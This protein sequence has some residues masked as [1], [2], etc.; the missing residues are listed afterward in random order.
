M[1]IVESHVEGED[2]NV[3]VPRGGP[4]YVS[5]FISPLTGVS[6]FRA[7]VVEHL[8]NLRA[9]VCSHMSHAC[10]EDIS[11]DELKIF[12][13]EEFVSEAFKQVFEGGTDAENVLPIAVEVP[14]ERNLSNACLEN[15]E[16]AI[17]PLDGSS[18]GSDSNGK[19]N[20]CNSRKTKKRRRKV[21]KNNCAVEDNYIAKV[22][23]L[24]KVKQK[25]DE[26]KAAVRLHSFNGGSKI[27]SSPEKLEGTKFL[28]STSSEVKLPSVWIPLSNAKQVKSL[29]IQ[30]HI[31]VSYPEVVLSVE[32][33]HNRRTFAKIQEF[34]VLGRQNLTE[35][36]DSIYC[37][38]DEIMRR[39]GQYD[40]SGYFL[41]ENVFCNDL[42]DPTA[43]DYSEPIFDWLTNSKDEALAKWGCIVT[44]ELQEKQKGILGEPRVSQ[45]PSF[46]SVD[47][48]KTRFC[49]LRFRLGAGYLYCHQGDCK[50]MI[51]IR[52]MRLI[53]PEDVNNQAAYPIA[54][55]QQKSRFRKCSV[56]K[57]FRAKK[58][59]VND[60]WAR[61]NPCYFCE[62]C[63]FLLHYSEDG[64]LLYNEF[65]VYD[66]FHD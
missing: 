44:G 10:E 21:N 58:V 46:K 15:L 32:V 6:D 48:Q 23:Q 17:V 13:D 27:N 8:Q 57:I 63:Y 53:H 24:V 56:C 42:R 39:A 45:L 43:I 66:Y 16:K 18:L 65:S 26:D 4:I 60:K 34:L 11:V 28:K 20:T 19:L 22:E 31:P 36:R 38:T 2:T 64:S 49:D 40:P 50:H 61:E 37:L 25:Q 14:N 12:S 3:S 55:F 33:Y 54:T 51:V 9:E 62:N 47:M 52:D 29:N 30:E 59:T 41:I 7:S 5:D 35:L 1:E